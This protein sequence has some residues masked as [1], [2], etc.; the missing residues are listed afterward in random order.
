M[1]QTHEGIHAGMKAPMMRVD[2][3]L[4]RRQRWKW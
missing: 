1:N 4:Q 3:N 2:V